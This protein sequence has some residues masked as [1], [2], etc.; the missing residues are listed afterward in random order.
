[1]LLLP[2]DQ[3]PEK[4]WTEKITRVIHR[5]TVA[6]IREIS[7]DGAF[8]ERIA[9]IVVCAGSES[10]RSAQNR[11]RRADYE[12]ARA[13]LLRAAQ[14]MQTIPGEH[15]FWVA[16]TLETLVHALKHF[17]T[18]TVFPID[19]GRKP[20]LHRRRVLHALA[21]MF[22]QENYPVTLSSSKTSE[23]AF[24]RLAELLF[25]RDM[26]MP[27]TFKAI[28]DAAIKARVMEG[29]S[30]DVRRA[31]PPECGADGVDKWLYDGGLDQQ[32]VFSYK[33]GYD[34]SAQGLVCT[35]TLSVPV[36]AIKERI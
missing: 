20:A 26:R 35:V 5:D 18:E 29:S 2:R 25:N 23:G 24:L 8:L 3:I 36:N 34:E 33:F 13:R 6:A 11:K 1:M 12:N 15:Q 32:K 16:N 31:L 17:P 21:A 7:N 22:R 28:R 9:Q 10:E 30:Y 19:K 27:G 14:D 4:E